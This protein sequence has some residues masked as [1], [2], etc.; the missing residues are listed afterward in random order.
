MLKTALCVGVI[1]VR[2]AQAKIPVEIVCQVQRAV[3]SMWFCC[4]FNILL[5]V[6][7]VYCV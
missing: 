1:G 6:V 3:P 2:V 4:I 5:C 7:Y